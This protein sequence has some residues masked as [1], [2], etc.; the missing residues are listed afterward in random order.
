MDITIGSKI[1][2]LHAFPLAIALFLHMSISSSKA[3]LSSSVGRAFLKPL[4]L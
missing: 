2:G 4:Y 1:T 3:S